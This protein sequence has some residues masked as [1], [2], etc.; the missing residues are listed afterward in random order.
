MEMS[1]FVRNGLAIVS[2]LAV[3]SGVIPAHAALIY[4]TVSNI[5]QTQLSSTLS[6]LPDGNTL[7]TTV[8][9]L[10]NNNAF[11]IADVYEVVVTRSLNGNPALWNDAL[12]QWERG[13]L[14]SKAVNA[15]LSV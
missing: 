13:G 10:T 3:A 7:S 2:F 14:V 9:S 11:A 15:A 1:R 12:Q 4:P 8:V 5:T 6:P